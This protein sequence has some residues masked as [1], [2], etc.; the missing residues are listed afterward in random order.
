MQQ[1]REPENYFL[2]Y[3]FIMCD[4]AYEP[5]W[6]CVPAFKSAVGNGLQLHPDKNLFNNA[7]AKPRVTCEHTMGLWKGRC[8]WLRNIQMKI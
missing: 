5:S 1:Y 7:I 4:T 8:P 3:E 6:F 2:G